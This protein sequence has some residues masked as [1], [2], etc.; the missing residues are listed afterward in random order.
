MKIREL[1][2]IL[3][4]VHEEDDIF[5]EVDECRYDIKEIILSLPVESLGHEYEMFIIKVQ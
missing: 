1:K 2:K 3:D 4:M 5:I